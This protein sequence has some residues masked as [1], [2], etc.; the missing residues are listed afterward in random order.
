MCVRTCAKVTE[1]DSVRHVGGST[2][3]RYQTSSGIKQTS[4][5]TEQVQRPTCKDAELA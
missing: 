1:N 2:R 3:F 5:T 4:H